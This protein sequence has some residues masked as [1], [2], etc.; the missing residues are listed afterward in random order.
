MMSEEK[1]SHGKDASRAT[2]KKVP[3]G[4]VDVPDQDLEE[5]AGGLQRPDIL[6]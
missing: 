3:G 2:Q 6:L 5:V 1:K 4:V